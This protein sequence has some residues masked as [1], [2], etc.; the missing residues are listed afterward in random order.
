MA[1]PMRPRELD[2]PFWEAIRSGLGVKSAAR[3]TGMSATTSKRVFRKAGGVNP[4]PVNPPVGRYLSW[5]EREDIAALTHA[6][7]GV[8]EVARRT[9]RSPATISR[10]LARGATG[11]GYRASVAQSKVDRGRTRSRGAKLATNLQLRRAVQDHLV[12]RRSPEQIAGRLRRDFPDDP[13]MRVS[14]ETIYQSLYIQAR[15]GLKRELSA[16]LRTGRSMRKPHRREAERRGRIPG[17][18]MI[19]ERPA[20]VEDRAVPGHWEGDLILGSTASKSAVG[21]LV[22]RSTGFVMLLHLPGDHGA[23]AVQEALVAKMATLPEQLRRSLTWDQGG[24]MA[25]HVAIAEATGLE[26]Y[27]CDP[28]SPWQRGSNE[29]TN[30]LLRQY[31]PKGTDLSFYGPG[32]LDNIASELNARPRKRHDFQTPAEVLDQLLSDPITNHGVA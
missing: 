14:P 24:E 28:H 3:V 9:G 31:L 15:G 27:F 10:E 21:T 32:L 2:R 17:M 22:E 8:R 26:I 6:G 19:S 1:R 4:V 18:V 30:G 23:L 7:H 5:V 25:N 20:E 13:E 12:Q 11:R 29:N 16:H